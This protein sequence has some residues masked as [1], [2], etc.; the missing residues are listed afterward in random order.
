MQPG[1]TAANLAG[2]DPLTTSTGNRTAWTLTGISLRDDTC[3]H[4]RRLLSRVFTV[5]HSSGAEYRLGRVCAREITGWSWQVALA[6][7]VQRARDL[8][9]AAGRQ[10]PQL[11]AL[12]TAAMSDAQVLRAQALEQG[13]SPTRRAAENA[14]ATLGEAFTSMHNGVRY[15]DG[16]HANDRA[17]FV[18]QMLTSAQATLAAND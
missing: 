16:G 13:N 12:V 14:I 2:S 10:Y 4:C 9:A 11:W 7:R 5:A 18:H 8:D 3:D 17:D 6:E 1:E 15:S